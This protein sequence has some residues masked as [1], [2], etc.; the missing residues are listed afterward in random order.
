MSLEN[1][2]ELRL[3]QKLIL[4]PQL[5]Q[6]IKLLQL[7]HLELSEFLSQELMENPFLE[8]SV[9]EVPF[10]ELTPEERDAAV[11]EE[12]DSSEQ[13]DSY[14]DTDAPLEKLMNFT[15]DE[16]F[17]ERSSDG[18]DMGYFNPGTVTP[19]SFEQFLTKKPGLCDHL[20]WQLRLSHIPEEIKKVGEI[21][22]GN[23]DE[24][25]YLKASVEEIGKA[26]ETGT[27]T[28]EK[29]LDI[30]QGFDPSG[31]GA[32]NLTECLL[33][34]LKALNLQNTIIEKIIMNNMDELEKRKYAVIAHKYDLPL[35]DIMTAVKVI[36]GLEPKPGRNFSSDDTNYI[37]PDVYLIRTAEGYQIILN[38]E[39]L[40]RLRVSSFYRKLIQQNNAYPKEDKQFLIDKMRSAVGLLKGLDQRS[41]TIYRVTETLIDLQ[42]EFFENGVQYLKPLTLKDVASI[43]SL[44][45]STISRVTSNKYISCEHGIFCFRFLFSS[46]LSRGIGSISSTSVKDT[47]KK[48]VTEEDSRKPMSDQHIAEMLS[49][50][51]IVIARRT[52]AKYREELGIP[53]QTQRRK[54]TN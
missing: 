48:I 47:I 53:S 26:A 18:R 37:V 30:I 42:N 27:E 9:D 38:D 10:E 49:K 33:I 31:V 34:Q 16:Y 6:A 15:A 24:N 21:V 7:P 52:V 44:H 23:I 36:E 29:A 40:P 32:R 45:E 25:G 19:P 12:R 13:E 2:L 22:I 1:R 41:R 20:L 43:L 46:A 39:G 3:S 14:E 17:E 35:K 51:S 11:R 50:S 5:Q 28:A 4:T 8:E 54:L